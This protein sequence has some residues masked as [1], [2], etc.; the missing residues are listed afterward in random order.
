MDAPLGPVGML[1][2]R[3]GLMP[4]GHDRA[5]LRLEELKR[6][7]GI[8]LLLQHGPRTAG[9]RLERADDEAAAPEERHVPPP[10]VVGRAAEALGD[11]AAG[12]RERAV[13]VHDG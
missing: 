2:Q 13:R 4:A 11:A 10:R 12:D 3:A 6:A 1:H 5:A 9:E 7:A 8:D